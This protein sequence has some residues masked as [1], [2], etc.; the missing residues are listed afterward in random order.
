[1]DAVIIALKLFPCFI[2][3]LF[4]KALNIK[5]ILPAKI[6][7][8]GESYNSDSCYIN[9]FWGL[10]FQSKIETTKYMLLTNIYSQELIWNRRKK[11]P[12]PYW[13]NKV[14]RI[15]KADEIR[16]QTLLQAIKTFSL[17]FLFTVK[18]Y[19]TSQCTGKWKNWLARG[20]MMYQFIN[21]PDIILCT[22]A[23]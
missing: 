9:I 7:N 11:W 17:A 3:L 8:Q 14:G 13:V 4:L 21:T 16:E 6:L 23:S 1:M 19:E 10:E 22:F 15:T 18:T 2:A 5:L 12:H 20:N